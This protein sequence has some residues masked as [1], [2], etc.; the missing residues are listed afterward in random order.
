[1]QMNSNE[2]RKLPDWGWQVVIA[3]HSEY[4]VLYLN[5]K[6]ST[7]RRAINLSHIQYINWSKVIAEPVTLSKVKEITRFKGCLCVFV[8]VKFNVSSWYFHIIVEGNRSNND[9]VRWD[10]DHDEKEEGL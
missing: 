3:M 8:V 9:E 4:P 6:S 10:Y 1:M 5:W 7:I 2:M